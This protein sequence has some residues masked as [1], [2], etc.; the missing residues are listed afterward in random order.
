MKEAE[1]L[2]EDRPC[3]Q[4]QQ[5]EEEEIYKSLYLNPDLFLFI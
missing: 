2:K 5:E 1:M 3:K 4:A